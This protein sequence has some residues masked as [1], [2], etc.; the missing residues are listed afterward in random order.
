MKSSTLFR[1][2][3]VIFAITLVCIILTANLGFGKRLFA[4]V[5][6]FPYGDKVG[7]FMLMGILSLLVSLSFRPRRLF[8][9]L[10]YSVIVLCFIV[11]LEEASQIPLRHRDFSL[12][13]LAANYAGIF[14]FGEIGARLY[15]L[16]HR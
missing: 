3:A 4:P 12:T 15:A 5:Y 16:L 11:T 13:D 14:V 6:D 9:L 8:G 2:L 10:L 1:I 7:H